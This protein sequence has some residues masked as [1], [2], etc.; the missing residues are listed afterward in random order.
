MYLGSVPD[1]A[2]ELSTRKMI[3]IHIG[4]L[5]RLLG[6][7][8]KVRTMNQTD[9]QQYIDRRSKEQGRRGRPVNPVTIRK[10]IATLSAISK[11]AQR[12]NLTPIAIPTTGLKYPK[13]IQK[14]PFQTMDQIRR[15]IARG[16]LGP[17]EID[18]LLGV[19]CFSIPIRLTRCSHTLRQTPSMGSSTPCFV[20]Q[21]LPGL[22]EARCFDLRLTTST[23][24]R[25]PSPFVK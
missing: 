21:R 3:E 6:K 24:I 16:G 13:A 11:W 5:K 18:E 12:A 20:L 4:H 7:R 9:I 14:P 10:E 17:D 15:R 25:A 2:I 22:D 8:T 1:T 23:L 19:P